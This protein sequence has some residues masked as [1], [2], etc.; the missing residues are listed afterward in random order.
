MNTQ[1]AQ[2]N[3]P[4]RNSLIWF[5]AVLVIVTVFVVIVGLIGYLRMPVGSNLIRENIN[6][7]LGP[8]T[9]ARVELQL[10]ATRLELDGAAKRGNL[11]DGRAETLAGI[12][13]LEHRAQPQGSVLTYQLTAY[14]PAAVREP[15]QWPVWSL[16]LN[17]TVPLE[18]S[19]S[20]GM[21]A[22]DLNLRDLKISELRLSSEF[23]RY[24]VTLPAYGRVHVRL[25]GGMGRME[26]RLPNSMAS[27]VQVTDRATGDVRFNGQVLR[28]GRVQTSADFETARDRT[29]L[30]VTTGQGHIV[31]DRV[32]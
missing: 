14:R 1:H 19:V 24:T 29:E 22:S 11:I 27:R 13:R 6:Q 10:G 26:M 30:E 20:G 18:L 23:A 15:A 21:P 32:P 2:Q 17:P 28:D 3:N 25:I 31:I 4:F 9:Q 7:P 16:H 5:F 12:E 8:A